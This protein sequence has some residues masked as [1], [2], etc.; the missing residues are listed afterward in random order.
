MSAH[1]RLKIGVLAAGMSCLLLGNVFA[2]Q[3]NE[4]NGNVKPTQ[5]QG[6]LP[7]R[8][9]QS[10]ATETTRNGIY[11]QS[12]RRY[13]ANF[14]GEQAAQ[15]GVDRYLASCLSVNNNGEIQI[16]QF[17][18]QHAQNEQV[19]Q[20]AQQL[21]KDHQ[22]LQQQIQ[23]LP[24]FNVAMS[25][26]A[27]SQVG[28]QSETGRE[29]SEAT[30]TESTSTTANES[31]RTPNAN[32]TAS[33]SGMGGNSIQ[34]LARIDQQITQRCGQMLKEELQQKSGASFDQAFLGA[35][36][37]S[38]AFAGRVGSNLT[39]YAGPIAAGSAAGTSHG[40]AAPRSCETTHEGVGFERK[41]EPS[42]TEFKPY[43]ALSPIMG[44][45]RGNTLP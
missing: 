36:W 38:H 26:N 29:T 5:Y 28:T 4:A 13:T 21:V 17:A 6:N 14:R 44:V 12:G 25:G 10:N 43:T 23:K 31:S 35:D 30:R 3:Q 24:S 40:S 45:S 22:Q 15:S 19:K 20:F 39:E 41:R 27:N 16:A 18:E 1:V 37:R 34:Q 42:G 9:G 7:D 33:E 8:T 32:G 11:G 2:Q